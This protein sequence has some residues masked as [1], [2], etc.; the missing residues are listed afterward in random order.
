MACVVR[1]AWVLLAVIGCASEAAT[2]STST[3]GAAFAPNGMIALQD[4]TEPTPTGWVC[5]S[6]SSGDPFYERF[7]VGAATAGIL[8]GSP[9]HGHPVALSVSAAAFGTVGVIGV[10]EHVSGASDTDHTHAGAN[11]VSSVG[12]SLPPYR[13][14][15]V[16]GATSAT[17]VLPQGAI[18][19]LEGSS[20]PADFARYRGQN[21]LFIRGGGATGT[22]GAATHAHTVAID[23]AAYTGGYNV[24]TEGDNC[25]AATA[26][27]H[28]FAHSAVAAS[29]EPAHVQVGL[30]RVTNAA[31]AIAPIGAIV[32]FDTIPNVNWTLLSG[33][34]G[35]FDGAF[36]RGGENGNLTRVGQSGHVHPSATLGSSGP[37]AAGL[38]RGHL[39]DCGGTD[40]RA[41][42]RHTHQATLTF[43][44]TDHRPPFRSVLIAR[45]TTDDFLVNGQ[46]CT[47][48]GEC[49]SGHC[50]DAVCCN[51][52]CGG[53]GNCAAQGSVG[54]CVISAGDTQC[55]AIAGE[56]DIEDRCDGASGECIDIVRGVGTVCDPLEGSL[57]DGLVGT[58]ATALPGTV[59]EFTATCGSADLCG[60]RV[61][62]P[63]ETC[64]NCAGD[65]GGCPPACPDG[66]CNGAEDCATC[67]SDCGVCAP[68]CNDTHCNGTE[69]CSS[70]PG[71][72]GCAANTYCDSG[73][74]RAYCPNGTCNTERGEN[75]GN[76]GDCACTGNTYCSGSSC[77]AYCPNGTCNTERGENCDTCAQDCGCAGNTFCDSGSCR[78]YCPNG[79]CDTGRGENCDTC[80]QDCGCNGDTYCDSGTCRN[81]CP[82]G[83]CDH[84]ENCS[85]C[86]R[87]CGCNGDAFCDSGTCR[88][89]C[90]NGSCDHGENCDT[91]AQDCGCDDNAYCESG[92]CRDYCPNG[93]CDSDRGENCGNCGDCA[94]QGNDVCNGDT[95]E[96]PDPLPEL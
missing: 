93:G 62:D 53:C 86:A 71:D 3:S 91:C 54:T 16:I 29:N 14:L 72:C 7:P 4:S 33:A 49:G 74:C 76:C 6:C 1:I 38:F 73:S 27:A 37:T 70:C 11:G 40:L 13:N 43:G 34:G 2:P 83:S 32:M 41:S 10:G 60:N 21:G 23:S 44:A 15:K 80:V 56:C 45:K 78:D 95:C 64:T 63:G 28:T 46:P 25:A 89:Y 94:C 47:L 39:R 9:T 84:G 75:C 81:Y 82:N 87:D 85:T 8:G 35:A 51:I 79:T 55:R 88:D 22:G 19:M 77:V 92:R 57:C 68:W 17:R 20:I 24:S 42:D 12:G 52:G 26:H 65:C 59:T 96:P 31:G 48:R 58:C 50:D 30:I 67:P 36:L 69:N 18:V 66:L 5:L 90:P 61:C